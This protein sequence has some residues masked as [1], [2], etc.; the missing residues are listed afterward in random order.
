VLDLNQIPALFPRTDVHVALLVEPAEFLRNLRG[1]VSAADHADGSG[2]R[3]VG[4]VAADAIRIRRARPFVQND[5][6]PQFSGRLTGDGR[7]VHGRFQAALWVRRFLTVWLVAAAA[8]V[9][10]AVVPAVEFEGPALIPAL[11]FVAGAV[12]PRLGWWA[13]RG[14][15]DKIE[16]ALVRAAGHRGA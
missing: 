2:D 10:V 16:A 5:F 12:L 3:L 1:E 15:R 14:D 11:M 6:A 8:F 9:I 7:Y 13:G 4:A